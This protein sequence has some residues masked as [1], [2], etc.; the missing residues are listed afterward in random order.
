L[1]PFG[2]FIRRYYRV[3][4]VLKR[5][6]T[7]NKW[8]SIS[9]RRNLPFSFRIPPMVPTTGGREFLKVNVMEVAMKFRMYTNLKGACTVKLHVLWYYRPRPLHALVPGTTR[10]RQH[11]TS[12]PPHVYAPSQSCDG[13]DDYGRASVTSI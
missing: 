6:L 4:F 9:L 3:V 7:S 1:L 2:N 10:I 8:E 13:S 11:N 5:M 12:C